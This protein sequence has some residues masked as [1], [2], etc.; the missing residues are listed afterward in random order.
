MNSKRV[1]IVNDTDF[2]IGFY[3]KRGEKLSNHVSLKKGKE[4]FVDAEDG[5]VTLYKEDIYRS[6]NKT[7]RFVSIL[8]AAEFGFEST[9]SDECM[10]FSIS[11]PLSSD[12]DTL[13]LSKII[14]P[15]TADSVKLWKKLSIIQ[16]AVIFLILL[17]VELVPF[18]IF[19]GAGRI[20]TVVISLLLDLGIFASMK[21]T[22]GMAFDLL[23]GGSDK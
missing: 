2:E 12:D 22:Y 17:L 21:K 3:E 9:F 11:Y 13:Y 10:P 19:H 5:G 4:C 15:G 7:A 1:K 23:K 8:T 20:A 18:F 6:E 14:L 16:T